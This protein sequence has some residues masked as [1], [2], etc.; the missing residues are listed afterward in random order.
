MSGL[1]CLDEACDHK[2]FER[3]NCSRREQEDSRSPEGCEGP[4]L[5]PL[6][7]PSC[8]SNRLCD[9]EHQVERARNTY[10]DTWTHTVQIDSKVGGAQ[11]NVF[12]AALQESRKLPVWELRLVPH[13]V[14]VGAWGRGSGKGRVG[15]RVVLILAGFCSC[16]EPQGGFSGGGAGCLFGLDPCSS[17][18]GILG[19]FPEDLGAILWDAGGFLGWSRAHHGQTPCRRQACKKQS[20]ASTS[21]CLQT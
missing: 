9:P 20:T 12:K 3:D 17:F 4:H 18:G 2:A 14:S 19:A 16:P 10:Y 6:R 5:T 21:L 1:H 15:G 11:T 8:P 7:C 13:G